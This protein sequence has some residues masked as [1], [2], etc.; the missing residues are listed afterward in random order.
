MVI[1]GRLVSEVAK[2]LDISVSLLYQWVRKANVNLN[3]PELREELEQHHESTDAMQ[4]LRRLRKENNTLKAENQ[5]LKKAAIIL[6]TNPHN[7]SGQ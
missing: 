7:K 4:E 2:N 5:I 6:G 3:S 1:N